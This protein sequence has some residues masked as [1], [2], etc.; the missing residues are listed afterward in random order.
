MTLKMLAGRLAKT[1][2]YDLQKV[3]VLDICC[4]IEPE[5]LAGHPENDAA[6]N[7]YISI[8]LTV[9]NPNILCNTGKFKFNRYVWYRYTQYWIIKFSKTEAI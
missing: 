6:I 5:S 2:G 8:P 3:D 4:R 9:P 1:G 7:V